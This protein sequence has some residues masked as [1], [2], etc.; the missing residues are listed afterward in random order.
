MEAAHYSTRLDMEAAHSST[1]PFSVVAVVA[2]SSLVLPYLVVDTVSMDH[3][4]S[5]PD[6]DMVVAVHCFLVILNLVAMVEA[7]L[8]WLALQ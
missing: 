8:F 2:P 7:A 6:S 3:A 4:P 1:S 5:S